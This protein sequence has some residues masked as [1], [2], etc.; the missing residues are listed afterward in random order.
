MI[1]ILIS[2]YI[3][4]IRCNDL[5]INTDEEL[6]KVKYFYF[7]KDFLLIFSKIIVIFFFFNK[8]I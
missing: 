2:L 8:D 5:I 6:L 7:L 1:N 3:N 4:I